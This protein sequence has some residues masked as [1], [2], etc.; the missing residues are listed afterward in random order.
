[1]SA[2]HGDR[3][4]AES[5]GADADRYDRVRPSYPAALIDE[6]LADRPAGILDVGTGTGI[7]AVLLHERGCRVLGIEPDERMA[8][9]ARGKGLEVEI[10]TLEDWPARG[11]RFELLTCAQ[12]W[13][14]IDPQIGAA[15]AAELLTPG[16]RLAAFWNFAAPPSPL[17][18]RFEDIY[19]RL[20]PELHRH[21]A[22]LGHTEGRLRG[23]TLAIER[24]GRFG[25]PH[26]RTWAWSR[27]Y[28]SALWL[29]HLL[30]HSDHKAL[31]ES[32]R[33]ALLEA[34]GAAIDACGGT[35]EV[36]YETH[37]VSARRAV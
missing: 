36:G 30:T 20:A 12:A 1:M 9:V 19:A 34:L 5:F 29:E 13:H 15:K 14:W 33:E 18:E 23:V 32:G 25:P 24:S 28:T 8:R 26:T 11:R 6:L 17:R 16:G 2:L 21:S 31:P 4:R 7:A 10:S 37:L 35:L 3:A 22:L 27:R